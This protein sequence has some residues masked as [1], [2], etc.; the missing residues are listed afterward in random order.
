MAHNLLYLYYYY[1]LYSFRL[2][3]N[4]WNRSCSAY[5]RCDLF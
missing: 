1:Q 5:T 2:R 3:I 4:K